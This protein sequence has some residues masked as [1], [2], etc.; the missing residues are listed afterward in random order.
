MPNNGERTVGTGP[1]DPDPELV[2]RVIRS[3]AQPHNGHL[4]MLRSGEER[5]LAVVLDEHGLPQ[6]VPTLTRATGLRDEDFDKL[7]R[8]RA[9]DGFVC[10]DDERYALV[11][12]K[13]SDVIQ[14]ALLVPR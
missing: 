2:L 6:W 12:P 13:P 5:W 3:G 14:V 10:V 1:T 4:R 9:A 11:P 8:G 7:A